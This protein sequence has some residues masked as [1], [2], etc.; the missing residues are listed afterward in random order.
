VSNWYFE[1]NGERDGPVS[2]NELKAM[3]ASR[4][5]SPA[6]LVWTAS[7]GSE[8]K[9]LNE[10]ELAPPEAIFPP[11]LPSKEPP[12]LPPRP[13][14]P[15]SAPN[16]FLDS[17][18][19]KALIGKRQE[20]YLTKWRAILAK[21]GDDPAKVATT[22]SWNW[23]ALFLPYGWL[24]YRK[25]YVLGGIA[26][27]F[28]LAYVL[29]PDSVPTSAARWF[30]FGTIGL[31]VV[32]ALYGDAWYLDAVRKRREALRQQPDQA[33]ALALAKKA[34]GVNVV[35]PVAAI[36]LVIAAAVIPHLNLIGWSDPVA[37]VRDGHMTA[38]PST[39]VGKAFAGNFDE[40]TWRSFTTPRGQK[41]VEFTGK[42]NAALHANA[43]TLLADSSEKMRKAGRSKAE[44]DALELNYLINL[45]Q[46]AH[47]D[48]DG[49]PI[50]SKLQQKW[51]CSGI[52]R[53]NLDGVNSAM[54]PSCAEHTVSFLNDAIGE[55]AE[56]SHWPVGMPVTAQWTINVNGD[57][58]ETSHVSSKAW[59]GL[60]QENVLAILF[61]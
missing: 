5:I 2:A 9:R 38:Y 26:L 60:D 17:E 31:G 39:T 19:T 12:A 22:S 57:G 25:L 61:Q 32:F 28:Q 45:F 58:F 48:L 13:E 4:D 8:W 44:A 20:H 56:V 3:L 18:L 36:A 49:K 42:I 54:V 23:P 37:L 10:T 14:Q 16:D 59:Q 47:R 50:L 27:A 11:P 1:K 43:V 41:V 33:A 40:G 53:A 51:G 30:L 6:N 52:E 21:A 34:G 29:L 46:I 7:L 24:L 35:A 55:W 15:A